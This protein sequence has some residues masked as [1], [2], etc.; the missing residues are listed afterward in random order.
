MMMHVTGEEAW[1]DCLLTAIEREMSDESVVTQVLRTA[2]M[3]ELSKGDIASDKKSL[4]VFW[5]QADRGL[6]L[7]EF[8]ARRK[9][10]NCLQL[11]SEQRQDML[12]RQND[13][14]YDYVYELERDFTRVMGSIHSLKA[15]KHSMLTKLAGILGGGELLKEAG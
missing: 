13:V 1:L 9:Y 2:D 4:M 8:K 5:E 15:K 7:L 11:E 6:D 12:R 3:S 10:Y 14:M